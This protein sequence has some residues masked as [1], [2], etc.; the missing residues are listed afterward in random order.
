MTVIIQSTKI[1]N[2]KRVVSRLI[3]PED[4]FNDNDP[5]RAINSGKVMARAWVKSLN[6]EEHLDYAQTFILK[7]IDA[8]WEQV[9]KDG[10]AR[11][12]PF[13]F[14]KIEAK[15]LDKSVDSVAAAIGMAAA[16]LSVSTASYLL[17]NVYTA[18]LPESIRTGQGVFYTPPALTA[19]LIQIAEENGVNW[20]TAKVIDPACG[21][22]AFLAPVC[23]K[24]LEVLNDKTPE[25]ILDHLHSHLVGW[26]IDPFGGWLSQVFIEVALKDVLGKTIL[27]PQAFV[28]ICNSLEFTSSENQGK[29]DLVI[30]NPPYG[31]IKLT[32]R[33]RDRYKKSLYGHPNLYGLFTHLAFQFAKNEGVV[34]LLTPTSFLSGEYFKNLRQFIRSMATPREIDFVSFRKGIFEDVL[35]ETMLAVYV[36]CKSPEEA[37]IKTNQLTPLPENKLEINEAGLYKMPLVKSAPWILPRNPDQKS[38]ANAMAKMVHRLQ[39]WGYAVSTG[40][41]VWNRH[42]TQLVNSNGPVNYPIIWAESVTQ[43]GR[44]VLKSEKR[45]H[46]KYFRFKS[47]DNWLVTKKPCILLQRTTAKEQDKRLVAAALPEEL[48]QKGVVVENHLNMIIPC[49]ETP[50]VSAPALAAFLNSKIVNDAFRTISGSVAVSAYE[51]EFLPLPA[52]DALNELNTIIN[53][54]MA[55]YELEETIKNIYYKY[56]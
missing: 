15:K 18:V 23:S 16:K 42:K 8:Y 14:K 3:T 47:G 26:E 35:Q 39:D 19:R 49:K 50:L 33:I 54:G 52:P 9:H 7:A 30:G 40:P 2:V 17:G 24:M 44:F 32:D 38:V 48:L 4:I 55:G 22:G 10:S 53:K 51:L 6:L 36:K 31:K 13:L 41:L 11:S 56:Q 37:V 46:S 5:V 12:L 27:K 20:A 45:N 1:N 43:D 29:Y 21:G 25:E 34:A 28:Q